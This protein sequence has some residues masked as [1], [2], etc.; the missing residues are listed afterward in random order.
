[1]PDEAPTFAANLMNMIAL[2]DP[3][4]EAGKG[5]RVKLEAEGWS[6]TVAEAL[7]EQVVSGLITKMLT[8]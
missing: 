8:S 2:L 4:F 1:M 3:V 6:P 5:L 7:A